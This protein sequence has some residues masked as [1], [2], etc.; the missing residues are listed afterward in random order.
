[1]TGSRNYWW[2]AQTPPLFIAFYRDWDENHK[3]VAPR[4]FWA[5]AAKHGVKVPKELLEGRKKERSTGQ[6]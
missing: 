4:E 5:I 3:G 2:Q 1:M 6:L